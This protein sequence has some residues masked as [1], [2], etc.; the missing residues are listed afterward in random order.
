M[1]GVIQTPKPYFIFIHVIWQMK[2]GLNIIKSKLEGLG[3]F[4]V[5]VEEFYGKI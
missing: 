2:V 3:F 4:V 1:I 5:V